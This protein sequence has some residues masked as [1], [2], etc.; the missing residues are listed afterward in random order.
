MTSAILEGK[1]VG[2]IGPMPPFRL[3]ITEISFIFGEKPLWKPGKG[4]N[5]YMSAGGRGGKPGGKG[6]SGLSP[7][8]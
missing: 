2:G 7:V 3:W 5:E 4:E 1:L 6:K 8:R